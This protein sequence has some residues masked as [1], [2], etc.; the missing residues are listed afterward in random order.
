MLLNAR[1]LDDT[2]QILLAIE[3]ITLKR[4]IQ[5]KLA[6]YIT[7]IEADKTKLTIEAKARIEELIDLNNVITRQNLQIK[8]L[9][10]IISKQ[11]AK[12]AL[13]LIISEK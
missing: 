2:K 11:N 7:Q 9:E 8:D 3:D 5:V 4:K 6:D 10:Q 13:D 1:Q 12:D